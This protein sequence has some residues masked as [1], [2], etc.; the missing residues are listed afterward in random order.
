MDTRSEEPLGGQRQVHRQLELWFADIM[1]NSRDSFVD[2][3]QGRNTEF[4]A[5][6]TAQRSNCPRRVRTGACSPSTHVNIRQR[7]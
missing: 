4:G 1:E 3:P 6:E 7:G 2:A 5:E